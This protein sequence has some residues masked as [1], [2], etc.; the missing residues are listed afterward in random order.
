MRRTT[1]EGSRTSRTPTTRW[2]HETR[3][4]AF[5][6][7]CCCFS[8]V[9]FRFNDSTTVMVRALPGVTIGARLVKLY[10][11]CCCTF[12]VKSTSIQQ[13]C[14]LIPGMLHRDISGVRCKSVCWRSCYEGLGP[15]QILSRESRPVLQQAV[16]AYL[17]TSTAGTWYH[18]PLR[19]TIMCHRPVRTML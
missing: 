4:S 18:V 2:R 1:A 8:R 10:P 5:C 19:L 14:C 3:C 15:G 16:V 17:P 6:A 11:K 9:Y 12:D 13:A 7:L